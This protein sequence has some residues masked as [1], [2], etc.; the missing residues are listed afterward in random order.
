LSG[1]KVHFVVLACSDKLSQKCLAGFV[2]G[3]TE[4]IRPIGSENGGAVSKLA[5]YVQAEKRFLQPL[6]VIEF[7]LSDQ[8]LGGIG[9]PENR[10]ILGGGVIRYVR[11]VAVGEVQNQ[12]DQI[13]EY[14]AESW[15]FCDDSN[16]VEA[17]E[18][19]AQPY[20][21]S[22]ALLRPKNLSSSIVTNFQG[23]PRL[24]VEFKHFGVGFDGYP[25]FRSDNRL[26]VSDHSFRFSS[27]GSQGEHH[28]LVSLGEEFNGFHYKLV[29]G[30]F[31]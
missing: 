27:D 22:L 13:L 6:D 24:Q 7:E 23:Q 10:L 2:L 9:Q 29:A 5:C 14:S 3:E 18:V 12:I 16:R 28:L 26:K 15:L 25:D 8:P 30:I 1:V 4:L 11:T 20:R 21:P 19:L 31:R 17:A